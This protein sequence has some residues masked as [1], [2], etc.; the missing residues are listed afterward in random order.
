M[1]SPTTPAVEKQRILD[2]SR[3]Y[4]DRTQS[5]EAIPEGTQPPS[6]VTA[7]SQPGPTQQLDPVPAPWK[8]PTMQRPSI[9]AAFDEVRNVTKRRSLSGSNMFGSLKKMLPDMPSLP[10]LKS[11]S[12]YSN[13]SAEP[14]PR[15]E[16]EETDKADK[17][18]D[19]P[20]RQAKAWYSHIGGS[21]ITERGPSTPPGKSGFHR[22]DTSQ[23]TKSKRHSDPLLLEKALQREPTA[24]LD[25]NVE[26]FLTPISPGRRNSESSLYLSRRLSGVSSYDDMTAFAHVSEMANSRLKALTDSFQSSTIRFPRL[27]TMKTNFG[28]TTP[29]DDETDRNTQL[30]AQSSSRDRSSGKEKERFYTNLHNIRKSKRLIEIE[31]S[32]HRAHPILSDALDELEGDL[33]ILGGYR[34]SILREAKSPNRQLWAPVKVGLNLRKADLEVGLTRED[35]ERAADTI[36]PGGVLSHIGPIDICRRLLKHS[37][38][39]PNL[40]NGTLRVHDWGY[41]WRLSPDLLAGRL[42]NFLEGLECNQPDQSPEKRGAWLIAHSLGGLI[43]RYAVNLRPELF[44]GVLYAGTPQNCVNIMGP[45]RNGD[46]V[47]LSSKVLTAQVNFTIRTSFALLPEDGRCFIQRDTNERLDL[48]FFDPKTWEDHHLSPCIKAAVDPTS[49][50]KQR[51]RSKSLVG[52]MAQSVSN[53]QL[54]GFLSNGPDSPRSG[55]LPS[56][57]PY[58]Q[59]NAEPARVESTTSDE[60]SSAPDYAQNLVAE[61]AGEALMEPSMGTNNLKP[62]KTSGATT[63]TLDPAAAREYLARTLKEIV[64]FKRALAHKPA[65]Q[66]ANRY[67]PHALIFGKTVP[68]VYGAKVASREAIKY[69]DSLDDLVFAAGDGVVLASAAQLPEGYRVVKGGRIESDRGH[70]GLMGD[71][72]GVGRALSALVDGRRKGVGMGCYA[73]VQ[74]SA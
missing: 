45:L 60:R 44:A 39:C 70:V 73:D 28:K 32:Q 59:I 64:A 57:P 65:Q 22:L 5:S 1:K 16:K 41:D 17:A 38:K 3:D 25:G 11:Q 27:P 31:T 35:E 56:K 15:T 69:A 6:P 29:T 20:E 13:F 14:S 55:T 30:N 36:V 33:V 54:P 68:T 37:R 21:D 8:A 23:S 52:M 9:A 61:P 40:K 62:H 4:F 7:S 26:S 49:V 24:G 71:L 53:L 46:D 63:S 72:E 51:D 74:K 18:S 48:D 58:P 2:Q 50:T 42:I 34:G 67:P 66:S 43:T 12:F 19:R 10:T 47:L